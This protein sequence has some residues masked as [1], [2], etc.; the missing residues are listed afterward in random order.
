M[1]SSYRNYRSFSKIIG[2]FPHNVLS[3][4]VPDTNNLSIEVVFG[5]TVGLISVIALATIV[6]LIVKIVLMK[7]HQRKP[8]VSCL[9][10]AVK[11]YI[12]CVFV[13]SMQNCHLIHLQL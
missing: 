12:F 1:V 6:I 7:K 5:L 10:R 11:S 9:F 4:T 13:D 2:K 3:F 8:Y